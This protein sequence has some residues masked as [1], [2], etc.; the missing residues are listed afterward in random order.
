MKINLRVLEKTEKFGYL[1]FIGY[2]GTKFD[3][4]DEM[5]NKH[6][7]KGDFSKIMTEIGFTWAKGVQQAGRTDA[8]VSAEENILYVSS[9]FLEDLD[10]LKR[11]FNS[12][13]Q[14]VKIKK[15]IKTLPNLTL[16]EEIEMREY[17]YSYPKKRITL[18][19]EE[20][21]E[22]C[23]KFSGTYDVSI[24]TDSKG[25]ELKEHIRTVKISYEDGKLRF[26][27]DS[28]MPKQVRIMSSYILTDSY[29][30]L[31][32]KYLTLEKIYVKKELENMYITNNKEILEQDIE[33]LT[34]AEKVGE[35]LNIFYVAK[36]NKGAFIGRNGTNIKKLKKIY[37]E[38]VVREI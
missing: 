18:S 27:G 30:P 38:I 19:E 37:G 29:E 4:F 32:G 20:I 14:S 34:K 7:V 3:A 13:S 1:F 28:F 16:P 22:R 2:N 24:F 33:G 5:K 23:R 25:K 26:L 10:E 35:N 8:K 15:I 31:P 9:R 11:E 6:T 12:R 17:L 21:L 36:G